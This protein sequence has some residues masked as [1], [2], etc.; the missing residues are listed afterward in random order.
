VFINY[1]QVINVIHYWFL[2][3]VECLFYRPS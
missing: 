2:K 1:A 3:F